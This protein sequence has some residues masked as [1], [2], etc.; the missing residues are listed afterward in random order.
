MITSKFTLETIEDEIVSVIGNGRQA[1]ERSNV[2]G[3]RG[4]QRTLFDSATSALNIFPLSKFI[5]F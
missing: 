5:Q 4:T 2:E 1:Y 3:L